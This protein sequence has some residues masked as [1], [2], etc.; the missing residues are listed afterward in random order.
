MFPCWNQVW[1]GGCE[2]E[3]PPACRVLKS[4]PSTHRVPNHRKYRPSFENTI[5]TQMWVA[6]TIFINPKA[7][8]TYWLMMWTPRYVWVCVLCWMCVCHDKKSASLHSFLE[9]GSSPPKD[10]HTAI[11]VTYE[12]KP[13]SPKSWKMSHKLVYDVTLK[14]ETN[15][16]LEEKRER[17]ILMFFECAN[18]LKDSKEFWNRVQPM[19]N[20]PS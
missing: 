20:K 13:D 15:A 18:L 9:N 16:W 19:L 10:W 7:K 12:N 2:D 11:H 3:A 4:P 17:W 6:H 8:S 1:R 14:R 5:H